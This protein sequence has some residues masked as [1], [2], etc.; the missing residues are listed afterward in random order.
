MLEFE[1][2]RRSPL[3]REAARQVEGTG[4]F[5]KIHGGSGLRIFL[6]G[7]PTSDTC[8]TG[9]R[10]GV[11]KKAAWG[12]GGDEDPVLGTVKKQIEELAARVDK[13]FQKL[14]AFL[15]DKENDA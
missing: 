15:N 13:R 6:I 5:R 1:Q 8:T 11:V 7:N 10:R 9:K 12:G 2:A 3:H 4:G 14:A